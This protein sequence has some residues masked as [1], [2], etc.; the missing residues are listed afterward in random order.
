[1]DEKVT[2]LHC[3]RWLV[4]D[5]RSRAQ[6]WLHRWTMQAVCPPTWATPVRPGDVLWHE[7]IDSDN[8]S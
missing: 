8:A 5:R 6:G 1:M 2:C 7:P 4:P 3:G